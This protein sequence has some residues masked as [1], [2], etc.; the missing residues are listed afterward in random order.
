MSNGYESRTEDATPGQVA[1]AWLMG[2]KSFIVPIPG[3]TKV[4]HLKEDLG[5]VDVNL[6]ADDMEKIEN[7]FTKIHIH[8]ERSTPQRK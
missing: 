4:D 8:G 2:K 6:S 7:A 5:A 1:L 3:T